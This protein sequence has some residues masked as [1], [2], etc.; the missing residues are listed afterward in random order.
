MSTPFM[1]WYC[2][3]IGKTKVDNEGVLWRFIDNWLLSERTMRRIK[4]VKYEC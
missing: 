2:C 1:L 4:L 3:V